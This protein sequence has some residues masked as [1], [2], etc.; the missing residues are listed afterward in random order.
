M[1][2]V[3]THVFSISGFE[4][5]KWSQSVTSCQQLRMGVLTP[6]YIMLLKSYFMPKVLLSFTAECTAL[7]R[8]LIG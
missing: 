7:F 6:R 8:V 4:M 1:L 2:P 3:I 5:L